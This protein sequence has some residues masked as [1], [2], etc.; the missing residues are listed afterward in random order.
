M[1]DNLEALQKKQQVRLNL[2]KILPEL[3]SLFQGIS[4]RIYGNPFS[5]LSLIVVNKVQTIG[6]RGF[7]LISATFKCE[8]GPFKINL[9]LKELSGNSEALQYADS[10][11]KLWTKLVESRSQTIRVPRVI[12]II[13]N[14]LVFEGITAKNYM[15]S[16]L[17]ERSKLVFAGE[18]LSAFHGDL[19]TKV[20]LN[21]TMLVHSLIRKIPVTKDRKNKLIGMSEKPLN[22]IKNSWGGTLGFGNFGK[23]HLLFSSQ[24][25]IGY[26]VDPLYEQQLVVCR[27]EDVAAFFRNEAI[28][29]WRETENLTTTT[30]N[31]QAF[32]Q[33]YDK[34]LQKFGI[35]LEDTYYNN[36]DSIYYFHLGMNALL[37]ANF[38]LKKYVDQLDENTVLDHLSK[39]VAMTRYCW[40]KSSSY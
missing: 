1:S 22:E 7:N 39:L 12:K 23:S 9:C 19:W 24:G 38:V 14:F 10:L 8:H 20:K 15:E 16:Q 11:D 4:N 5:H 17:D 28:A 21:Y 25:T 35:S 36:H 33:G 27:L 37:E 32:K 40:K 6:S 26:L 34:Q 29:E 18:L 3:E 31:W 30:T 13:D 2:E